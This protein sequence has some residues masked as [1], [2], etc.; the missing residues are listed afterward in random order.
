MR[1]NLTPPHPKPKSLKAQRSYTAV[2]LN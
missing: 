2:H 1:D